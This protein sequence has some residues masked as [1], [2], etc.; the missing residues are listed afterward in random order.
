MKQTIS[1]ILVVLTLFLLVSCSNK[2]EVADEIVQYYNEEWVSMNEMKEETMNTLVT[3]LYELDKEGKN[4]EVINL[5]KNEFY[6]SIDNI[7][8]HL[9]SLELNN[10]EVKKMN[11][12]QIE[13][14][15]YS[16]DRFKDTIEYYEGANISDSE[17]K[18]LSREQN[19]KYDD[20]LEYRDKLM[21]K[22]NLE[23]IEAEDSK[24]YVLKRVED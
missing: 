18:R 4:Q 3:E 10:K 6:P 1:M 21:D 2:G 17:L 23:L 7:L 15:K 8:E 24:S 12:M 14:E 5:I 19:K 22:Y 9:E 16:R 13:A 11:D 20:V